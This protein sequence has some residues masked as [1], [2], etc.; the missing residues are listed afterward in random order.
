MNAAEIAMA[1]G[2]RTRA[3]IATLFPVIAKMEVM[4]TWKNARMEEKRREEMLY[5]NA[6]LYLQCDVMMP[7]C[8][9]GGKRSTKNR[10]AGADEVNNST[11]TC[12]N[13]K[14]RAN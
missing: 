4:P 2:T 12:F 9:L 7:R 1:I 6:M 11:S 3:P 13:S 10:I 14:A 5:C 8:G